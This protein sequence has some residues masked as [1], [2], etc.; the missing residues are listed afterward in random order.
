M[1]DSEEIAHL[2][3]PGLAPAVREL[4]I[5]FHNDLHNLESS[6]D[7]LS[8]LKNLDVI[9]ELEAEMARDEINDLPKEDNRLTARREKLDEI[10]S[11]VETRLWRNK[12]YQ[13]EKLFR[14]LIDKR[15]LFKSLELEFESDEYL[16]FRSEDGS[17]LKLEYL[18][19]GEQ[20]LVILFFRLIFQTKFNTLVMID[21]PELSMNVVWQRNFLKDLQRI[22]ELRKFDVLIATHSPM[23]IHD[24]WDWVVHLGERVDD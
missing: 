4:E 5:S 7:D 20:Q 8:I 9:A 1:D 22:I 15:I 17:I 16:G 24:K 21:E 2:S 10:R 14:D 12:D 13:A 19:T 3:V 11:I 23:I 6:I 18:S